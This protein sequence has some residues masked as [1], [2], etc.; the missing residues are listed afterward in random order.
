MVEC[1]SRTR[2]ALGSIPST[3][4]ISKTQNTLPA[5]PQALQADD[6]EGATNHDLLGVSVCVCVCRE[7][8]GLK[9]RFGQSDS[10]GCCAMPA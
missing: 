6:R 9:L 7:A 10:E 5:A 8:G 1:S 2:E 4:K 3:A